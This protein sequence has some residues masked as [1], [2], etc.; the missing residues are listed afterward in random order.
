MRI[1][2]RTALASATFALGLLFQCRGPEDSPRA[3]GT[4]GT[5][6]SKGTTPTRESTSASASWDVVYRVLQHPRCMNCHPAGDVPLQGDDSRPHAQNVM[7]GPVGDGRFAMRCSTCHQTA[8]TPGAHLPPGAPRWK[9]PHP[10][11]PLVFQ[12]RSSGELCRQVKDK[13]RN[14]N[15]TPE[16]LLQHMA[17]DPL[18][19]WG[20]D[21]GEGR[22]PV[23]IPREEV[24][25]AMKSWIEGGCNC[26]Q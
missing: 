19:G 14:G 4:N 1:L 2:T 20:W 15:K 11:M 7:R 13:A 21:P 3:K 10:D 5:S 22:T 26:P 8:N 16:Q 6:E 25:A 9:L 18:V 24:I 12:G 17:K 23:P